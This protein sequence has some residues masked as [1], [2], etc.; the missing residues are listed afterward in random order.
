VLN[1]VAMQLKANPDA[2]LVMEGHTDAA[3][4]DDYNVQLGEKRVDA[5]RRYLVV[6]QE[7]PI[8]RISDMSFGKAKPINPDKGK[9]ARAQNRSVIIRVMGPQF[10]GGTVSEARPDENR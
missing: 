7:V 2:I 5:V 8:N 10:T 9:E 4:P 3:G 1:D 6:D